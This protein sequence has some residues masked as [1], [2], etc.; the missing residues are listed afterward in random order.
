MIFATSTRASTAF[1]VAVTGQCCSSNAQV[2]VVDVDEEEE[3]WSSLGRRVLAWKRV[4]RVVSDC[5]FG[6]MRRPQWYL[7]FC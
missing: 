7:V 1:A 4:P 2:R 3:I 5:F 6:A